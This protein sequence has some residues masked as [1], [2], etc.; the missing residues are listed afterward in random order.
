M[1]ASLLGFTFACLASLGRPPSAYMRFAGTAASRRSSRVAVDFAVT[2]DAGG[3]EEWRN[4]VAVAPSGGDDTTGRD[5]GGAIDFRGAMIYG[6][7]QNLSAYI[8]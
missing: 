6:Q 1:T 3:D 4:G 5:G 7:G 2:S 8:E